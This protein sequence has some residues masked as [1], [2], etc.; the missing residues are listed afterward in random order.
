M[1]FLCAIFTN[2]YFQFYQAMVL[3]S[4]VCSFIPVAILIL[5]SEGVGPQ[6]G[7]LSN[8]AK[9]LIKIVVGILSASVLNS[10]VKVCL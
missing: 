2:W 7:I 8:L 1:V 6:R 5:Q 9:L 10:I 4:L 3:N